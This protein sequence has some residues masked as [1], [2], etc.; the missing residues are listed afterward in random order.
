MGTAKDIQYRVYEK[1]SKVPGLV[2]MKG[3]SSL[4]VRI[5]VHKDTKAVRTTMIEILQ[6]QVLL[7]QFKPKITRVNSQ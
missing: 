3:C 1:K 5:L 4:C 6:Q 2:E 7:T